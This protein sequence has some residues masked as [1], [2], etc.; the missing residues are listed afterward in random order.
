MS[1]CECDEEFLPLELT[2]EVSGIDAGT[3]PFPCTDCDANLNG[4][5]VLEF[6]GNCTWVSESINL[7]P[8]C[9]T[10]AYVVTL[11]DTGGGL[12]NVTIKLLGFNFSLGEWHQAAAGGGCLTTPAS[13][14]ADDLTTSA[15]YC[16]V[17]S[18]TLL[19]SV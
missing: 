18:A 3:H 13:L 2:L 8:N 19:L 12:L 10:V 17:S 9:G 7:G 16:D 11:G 14:G 6:D 4:T 1:S 5:F 15:T